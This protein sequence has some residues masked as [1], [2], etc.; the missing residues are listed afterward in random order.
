[1]L[2]SGLVPSTQPLTGVPT[3]F[4]WL[5]IAL[6][7]PREKVW[8]SST[9]TRS[10]KVSTLCLMLPTSVLAWQPRLRHR[11]EDLRGLPSL[12]LHLIRLPKLIY[13]V[14]WLVGYELVYEEKCQHPPAEQSHKC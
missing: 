10:L 2:K 6:E 12:R 9:D 7:H 14:R 3:A 5:S 1:M 8:T 4:T 11:V 13:R